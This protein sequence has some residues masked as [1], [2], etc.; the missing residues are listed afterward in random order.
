MNNQKRQSMNDRRSFLSIFFVLTFFG[1][2]NVLAM[3]GSPAFHNIRGVTVVRLIATGMCFGGAIFSFVAYFHGRRSSWRLAVPRIM[4]FPIVRTT[5]QIRW[6][7]KKLCS[8]AFQDKK[9]PF[10]DDYFPCW[11]FQRWPY[12]CNKS[13]GDIRGTSNKKHYVHRHCMEGHQA[14]NKNLV[15]RVMVACA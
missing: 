10:A 14:A 11:S 2:M 4:Y 13:T 15:S 8:I 7:I 3:I 1:V 9:Y 12:L 6:F 5:N